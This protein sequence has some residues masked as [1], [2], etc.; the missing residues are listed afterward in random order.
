[1]S[2]PQFNSVDTNS[3]ESV[4]KG[5]K[6]TPKKKASDAWM[7]DGDSAHWIPAKRGR[8]KKVITKK[9]EGIKAGAGAS[10]RTAKY[11][12]KRKRVTGK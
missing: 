6:M 2:D 1:M 10:G 5:R 3:L 7:D 12:G 9:E 8:K 11:T 4:G